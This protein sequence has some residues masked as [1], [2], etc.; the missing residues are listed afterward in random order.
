MHVPTEPPTQLSRPHGAAAEVCRLAPPAVVAAPSVGS[1]EIPPGLRDRRVLEIGSRYGKMSCF[2]GMLGAQVL[3]VDTD[4]ASIPCALEERDRHGLKTVEFRHYTGDLDEI[5]EEFDFIFT[6]SVLVV[7]PD[8]SSLLAGI[9][10][11]LKPNGELLAAEN[12]AGGQL[13]DFVRRTVVHR[14]WRGVAHKLNGVDR[15]FFEQ[16]PPQLEVRESKSYWGL[17]TAVRARRVSEGAR[18]DH[19]S[20]GPSDDL[21]RCTPWAWL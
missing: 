21:K 18:R 17:V 20:D 1:L 10:G 8:L 5:Q 19:L 2:F 7:V 15:R 6:K 4:E 9:A 12:K 14:E 11:R 16:F 3:G 13:L